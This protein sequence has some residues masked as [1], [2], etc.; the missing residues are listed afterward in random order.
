MTEEAEGKAKSCFPLRLFGALKKMRS[1]SDGAPENGALFYRD[2]F[3]EV[4]RLVDIATAQSGGVIGEELKQGR[5]D[6]RR[7][8]T[9]LVRQIDQDVGDA[10]HRIV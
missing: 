3:R 9:F 7:K 1:K 2:G 4:A 10:R 6:D 5:L 8:E